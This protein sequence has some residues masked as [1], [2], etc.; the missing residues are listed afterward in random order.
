M[1]RKGDWIQ[2]YTGKKF[3]PLDPIREDIDIADIA[4]ALSNQ[5][6]FAGHCM[7][8][9]S[10]AEHCV[11]VSKVLPHEFALAGLLHDAAEAYLVDVPRPI[12]PFLK[13]YAGFEEVLITHIFARFNVSKSFNSK[14]II[15]ADEA[16]LSAESYQVMSCPPVDWGISVPPA[17]IK[18]QFWTPK[19]A[20]QNF[21]KRFY[22]L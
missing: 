10:V 14:E 18:V 8:F 4:H 15:N 9:Y 5:C 12:K 7:H 11:H 1:E 2:T 21:L 16:V 3:W 22:T 20:E 19:K 17:D 6:R 13:E